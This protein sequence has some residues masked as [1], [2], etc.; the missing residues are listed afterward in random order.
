M[1]ACRQQICTASL[2]QAKPTRVLQA[3][4]LFRCAVSPF[5]AYVSITRQAYARLPSADARGFGNNAR[6]GCQT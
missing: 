2:S 3:L 6:L 1:N 5:K 4:S